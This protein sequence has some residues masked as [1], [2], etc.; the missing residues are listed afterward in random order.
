M[1]GTNGFM[2][3]G[4]SWKIG[5]GS[6]AKL[7]LLTLAAATAPPARPANLKKL[8]LEFMLFS[9]NGLMACSR[10]DGLTLS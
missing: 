2:V 6:P 9:P 4:E 8:R 10:F 7:S 3:S 1:L 5:S